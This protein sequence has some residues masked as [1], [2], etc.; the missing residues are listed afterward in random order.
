MI[1]MFLVLLYIRYEIISK[2]TAIWPA[3]FRTIRRATTVASS[4]A[5]RLRVQ[6]YGKIAY[7]A[8]KRHKK[9]A[10]FQQMRL[11]VMLE[12]ANGGET[13]GIHGGNLR[14]ICRGNHLQIRQILGRGQ[15]GHAARPGNH[16]QIRQ[17][18]K[19][20]NKFIREWGEWAKKSNEL[21]WECA[22][23]RGKPTKSLKN[24][25]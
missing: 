5:S 9:A 17:I 18:L 14:G 25:G 22:K 19:Y 3:A 21:E 20:W 16:L 12:V 7:H 1:W 11:F 23:S 15:G 6:R 2:F 13:R 24:Q 4:L 8:R 10:F